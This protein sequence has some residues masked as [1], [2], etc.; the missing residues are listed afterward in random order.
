MKRRLFAVLVCVLMLVMAF[1]AMNAV[2]DE[3]AA[4]IVAARVPIPK[5][6]IFESVT[7]TDESGEEIT[8]PGD[9][10][11]WFDN[12]DYVSLSTPDAEG[13]IRGIFIDVE[14]GSVLMVEGG[15]RV[16]LLFNLSGAECE[17][18]FGPGSQIAVQKTESGYVLLT[19]ATVEL[20]PPQLEPIA[21][22]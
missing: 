2:A 20:S 14:T 11:E 1:P 21:V 15:D 8:M 17:F 13:A 4:V 3:N 9:P 22:N 18:S 10:N 16:N 7:F 19:D 6:G 5:D 12:A